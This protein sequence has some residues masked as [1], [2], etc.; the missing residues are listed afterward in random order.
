V[1]GAGPGPG[2]RLLVA[3]PTFN[4]RD[5]VPGLLAAVR[6]HRPDAHVLVVDDGSPDG[7]AALVHAAAADDARVHLLARDGKRGIGSAYRAAFAW[8]LGRGYALVVSMDADGSHDAGQIARLL[9]AVPAAD[10]V[11][12]SRYVPGGR[13]TRWPVH[14]RALSAA[15]NAAARLCAGPGIRDWTSG[16]K[17]YRAE[18]LRALDWRAIRSEGY[19]FQ[20]E[21]LFHCRRRGFRVREVPIDFADRCL[22]RTKMSRAEVGQALLTLVRL[23]WRRAVR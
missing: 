7:T 22:G 10:V 6:R 12:G 17:C 4:E 9:D 13:I 8:A 2:T 16:F 3:V 23:G 20:V 11:V 14:R 1:T 15:G 21:V 5:N 18:V 19:A